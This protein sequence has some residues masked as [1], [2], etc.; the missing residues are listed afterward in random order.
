MLDEMVPSVELLRAL[1]ELD[2]GALDDEGRVSAAA[3]WERMIAFCTAS[4]ND[5]LAAAYRDHR[6]AAEGGDA[7]GDAGKWWSEQ[8]GLALGVSG[9]SAYH[10]MSQAVTLV[11]TA[12]AISALLRVG[13]ITV[14]HARVAARA[15]NVLDDAVARTVD[16]AV[17][18][19][20][21]WRTPSQLERALHTAIVR[22]DPD[23]AKDRN[24]KR[25]RERD[26]SMRNEPDGM[27]SLWAL[28]P[29]EQA[30]P[31]PRRSRPTP[32]L[33]RPATPPATTAP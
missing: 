32:A 26:V 30:R 22:V 23:G 19:D 31:S 1:T 15:L 29:A 2:P 25:R 13:S 28:I 27:C 33:P 18:E 3:A 14:H 20:S 7:E 8:L 24:R 6:V 21:S 9:V 5:V 4:Q 10:R 11:E 16:A 17:A 12:P